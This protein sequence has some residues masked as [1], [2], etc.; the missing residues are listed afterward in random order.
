V[1]R[2]DSGEKTVRFLIDRGRLEAF[3]ASDLAASA[4]PQVERATRRL[5]ATARAALKNG[6]LDGAYAAAYDSYRMAAEA[7]LARQG[8]RATGG[9]GSH[10]A[11]EDAVSAQ[12]A[13]GIPAFAK[14]AFERFRRTRHTAQYFDPSAAPITKAD[15]EWAIEKATGALSGVKTL[16][17][18]SPPGRFE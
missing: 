3:E 8:L 16:F 15:A 11:V 4:A 2:W 7:L 10:M 17:A 6:D 12:F 18:A 13:A 1:A 9:D 5:E 14:P